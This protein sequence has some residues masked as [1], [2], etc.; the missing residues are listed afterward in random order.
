MVARDYVSVNYFATL[1]IPVVRGRA[2]TGRDIAGD[3]STPGRGT[4]TPVILNQTGARRIF[5]DGVVIGRPLRTDDQQSYVVVGVVPDVRSAFLTADA[6]PTVFVPIRPESLGWSWTE[7]TTVMVRGVSGGDAMAPVRRELSRVHPDLTLFDVRTMDEHLAR[8]DRIIRFNLR[9]FGVLGFFGLALGAI[10]LAGVASYAVARQHKEI[11]IRL[12]LGA[13]RAQVL[14]AVLREATVLS[15]AGA[16]VGSG[17]AYGLSRALSAWI[18]DIAIFGTVSDPI[19]LVGAAALFVAI[20]L[21]ACCVPASRAVRIDP[22]MTL[23]AE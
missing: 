1:G 16:L 12:A 18:A 10:G 13:R 6:V 8:F 3:S 5:E 21:A 15:L 7:G 23:R 22:A 2:L 4:E 9:Q 17:A 14:S 19:L 20:V 11:G